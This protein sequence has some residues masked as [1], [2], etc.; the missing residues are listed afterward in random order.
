[1]AISTK[2]KRK[3]TVNEKKY[4]WWIFDEFDQTE[5]DGLQIKIISENQN[6]YI[7][8]GLQQF[9]NNN[10]YVSIG[11]KNHK[12]KIHTLSPKFEDENGIIKPSN[13][14]KLIKWSLSENEKTISHCYGAK[15]GIIS[16]KD[17]SKTH[18]NIISEILI[19]C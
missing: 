3:I 9:D 16:S 7:K 8:Y 17:F 12:Y 4:F 18:K 5:F 1:M 6:G 10:R 14:E 19:K 11:L 15:I 2:G 13:I